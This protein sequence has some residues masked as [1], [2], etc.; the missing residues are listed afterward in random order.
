MYKQ[1]NTTVVINKRGSTTGYQWSGTGGGGGGAWL[2]V[3]RLLV[4]S[5]VVRAEAE[6]ERG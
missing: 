1:L 4:I 2:S 6:V 5:G 3:G